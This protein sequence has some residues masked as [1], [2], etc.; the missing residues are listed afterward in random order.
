VFVSGNL[1]LDF[2]G[3]LKW[4][5]DDLEELLRTPADLAEW[6]VEAGV[7]SVPPAVSAADL[8]R[9]TDLREAVYRLAVAAVD[10]R[11]LPV[12]DVDLVNSR[13]TARPPRVAL[14]GPTAVAV[15]EGDADAVGWAVA[16]SAID[17]LTEVAP[18]RECDGDRC[19]RLF[20]D[21]SRTGNRRWCGMAECGNRFK[22]AEYRGRKKSRPSA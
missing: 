5:H 15:R 16:I 3:T 20:V 19:T 1:A 4:R 6:G 18:V 7:L 21:R 17:L 22:A 13:A 14:S 9:L 2:A 10:G 8:E 11:D 12:E